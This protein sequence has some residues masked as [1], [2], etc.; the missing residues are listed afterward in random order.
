MTAKNPKRIGLAIVAQAMH[1]LDDDELVVSYLADEVV[2]E[3]EAAGKPVD[4]PEDIV[5]ATASAEADYPSDV[6]A[7]ALARWD[8]Q[9][10]DEREAYR[11]E[12]KRNVEA[13][14]ELFRA[15]IASVG[16]TQTFGMM[17]V[18]FFGLAI[19]TAFKVGRNGTLKESEA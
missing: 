19:L 8:A 9:S 5:V 15:T 7:E 13:N 10:A 17:D 18:I 3:F 14:A 2:A 16:F 1:D 11:A 6:W 4:W 12:L